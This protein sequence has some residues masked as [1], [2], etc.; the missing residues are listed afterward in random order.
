MLG[1][2]LGE[3]VAATL[4][5]VFSLEDALQVV[6][7]R[8]QL[9]HA[10]PPGAMLA[11]PLGEAEIAPM[12]DDGL[13]VA[14]VNAPSRSVVSGPI[15]SIERLQRRLADEG[16]DGRRLETSHAFHSS[17]MDPVVERFAECVA[18]VTLRPPAHTWMSNVTGEPI[19]AADATDPSYWARHLRQP[20]RFAPAAQRLL[21]DPATVFLEVGPGRTLTTLL[22][23]QPE[24]T[25]GRVLATSLRHPDDASEDMA[26]MAEAVGRLWSGGVSIDWLAV[27][28]HERLRRVPLPTYPFKRQRYWIEPAANR[29]EA[30][31]A[32]RTPAKRADVASWFYL[33]SWKRA[34]PPQSSAAPFAGHTI[35][36][37][38]RHGLGARL[39]DDLRRAG[40]VVQ[41]SG[42]EDAPLLM[43][44]LPEEAAVRVIDCTTLGG[45]R[46]ARS[47]PHQRALYGEPEA[48]ADLLHV[49][50]LCRTIARSTREVELVVVTDGLEAVTGTERIAPDKATIA[51]PLMVLS[52]ER[53]GVTSRTID[54]SGWPEEHPASLLA[55]LVLEIAGGRD[56]VVAWRHG[57]RWV[58]AYEP[59]TIERGPAP[60]RDRGAYLITGGLGG[61]GLILADHMATTYGARLA[62]VGRSASAVRSALVAPPDA[63][64]DAESAFREHRALVDRSVAEADRTLRIRGLDAYPGLE[65]AIEGLCASYVMVLAGQAGIDVRPGSGFDA[66]DLARRLGAIAPF[67][68]MCGYFE[69]VLLEDGLVA[70]D[71]GRLTFTSAASDAAPSGEL[72]RRALAAYPQFAGMF[73]LLDD[74]AA[75][76]PAALSGVIPAIGVLYPD[77]EPA[78]LERAAARTVAHSTR[79]VYL[80]AI[81]D[82]IVG[83][84][85]RHP[86]RRVRV[87]E[88]G[89]GDG[90]L[91]GVVAPA[92]Q[93]LPV[94][95]HA[96]DL[97]RSFVSRAERA[98]AAAGLGHVMRFGV[99]DI[100]RDPAG[101][102]YEP[103]SFDVVLALDVLHATPDLQETLG[104]VRTLLAPGGLAAIVET[105]RAPRWVDFIWGLAEGWWA[106]RD[107]WRLRHSPLIGVEEWTRVCRACG[108]TQVASWPSAPGDRAGDYGL[109]LAQ[110]PAAGVEPHAVRTVRRLRERGSEVLVL[111]ADVADEA[112]MR[113]AIDETVKQ[114]GRLDGVIHAAGVTGRDVI[115]NPIES[116]GRAELDAVLHAKVTGT[117]VLD[118]LLAER[119]VDF[120]LLVSSNASVLGGLGLSAYAAASR[121]LD[122]FAAARHQEGDRRWISSNW[123]G[124]PTEAAAGF[125]S[126]FQT[127]I[128]RY[129]MSL[130]ECRVAFERVLGAGVPQ[131]VVS[132]G[133][134]APRLHRW[135][136]SGSGADALRPVEGQAS[137]SFDA[138]ARPDASAPFEAPQTH[139]ERALAAIW[140]D[141]LGVHPIGSGDVFADLGGDSLLG[142]QL[143]SRVER[144]FG[145]RMPFRMLF[146]AP[147]VRQQ[148]QCIDRIV[149]ERQAGRKG[150]PYD[151]AEADLVTSGFTPRPV[152]PDDR[153]PVLPAQDSYPLSHAQR[154]VWVLSQ[155][156]GS[157]AYNIPLHQ[158]LDG[159]LDVPALEQAITCLVER[160]ETLRT[161]FVVA[162][163]EPR[164]RVDP[165]APVPLP[166]VDL[167]AGADADQR[168]RGLADASASDP[169]DLAAD[170]FRISLLRLARDR[171]IL[172]FTIHHIACDGVSIGILVRDLAELYRA[173]AGGAAPRLPALAVQ[174]RDYAG[175]QHRMLESGALDAER[176][177]WLRQLGADPAAG[178]AP[179]PA[180]GLRGDFPR[181]AVQTFRGRERAWHL[182]PEAARRVAGLA[183]ARHVSL[184]MLLSACVKVLL[185]R[186]TGQGD[187]VIGTPVAGR[188]HQDLEGQIGFYLNMLALRDT[189]RASMRFVDV[190]EAVR[191]TATAAYDRQAYPF[192]RLVDELE[193]ERDLSRSPIFDVIVMLQNQQESELALEGLQARPYFDHNGTSKA[194]LTFNFKESARGLA[195][196]I[197]Y[198]TDLFSDGRVGQIGGHLLRVLDAVTRDPL[199]AIGSIELLSP[200]ERASLEAFNDTECRY[201]RDLTVVDLV[202]R[203]AAESSERTAC[204]CGAGSLSYRDLVARSES[205]AAMLEQQGVRPGDTV[206]LYVERSIDLLPALLGI[207][208]TG[209]AYVPLDPAFPA[210]R[211]RFMVDDAKA[212]LVLAGTPLPAE[213]EGV[214]S[215]CLQDP[216]PA[217]AGHNVRA[218]SRGLAYVIY[219]S[220]STGRPKGVAIEHRSLVNF[221]DSMQLEPGLGSDDTLLAVTTLSFD[222]AALELF[223]PLVCGA[224]V[225]I[226]SREEATD[227]VRLQAL[228]RE[229]GATV[230]QATPATW[231]ML[232]ES[233]WQGD[234]RLTAL[235]GGEALPH[236]LA[237]R[238]SRLCRRVWNMYGPTET[239]IWSSTFD[240]TS[241]LEEDETPAGETMAIGWPIANTSMHVL[242]AGGQPAPAGVPGELYIGGEGLA[243][244]YVNLPDVTAERFVP[245]PF[246]ARHGARM[247]RTGDLAVRRADS[248]IEFLGRLDDQVKLRGFRIE[249]GEIE[250]ALLGHPDVA[251]AAVVLEQTA[252]G[253]RLLA[254]VVPRTPVPPAEEAGVIDGLRQHLRQRLP[255]YMVPGAFVA[256]DDLPRTP[257]GKVDRT[258]L[259]ARPAASDACR[260]VMLP[261]TPMEQRV[262]AAWA[263]V[264]DVATVDVHAD[265]FQL[266]GHSLTAARLA[267]RMAGA[268]GVQLTLMD[269][270]QHPT[271]AALA[272]LVDERAADGCDGAPAR[273]DRAIPIA[274]MTADEIDL[275]GE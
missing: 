167:T 101:Q 173:A 230:M 23:L 235:C 232:L 163:G 119:R 269:I 80:Q 131:V 82:A 90:I 159:P 65:A 125:D 97:G 149:E 41:E 171:H 238:L 37:L 206:G 156:G 53:P 152:A 83:L 98:A 27:H 189:L 5:G 52:Q 158:A 70:R 175:W 254:A 245:D 239:T 75:T 180:L 198:S 212:A 71:G 246:A 248:T 141:L 237:S 160:H 191:A 61:V 209:A 205:I 178:R 247:Y 137:A 226:A 121:F 231:Q 105:V 267:Y 44:S 204:C 39:A 225:V 50:H 132:S 129:A 120:I 146:E 24:G 164:Q 184:F 213:F 62:L 1:H 7:A 35:V 193:P 48:P 14:S 177:Y 258:A 241:A 85:A 68:R 219:T 55:A 56:R 260:P 16:L 274:P 69:Q 273:R 200:Q 168:A 203:T 51:G 116:T 172:L 108:Y 134:L 218:T 271:V 233:G 64:P 115:V 66:G 123:D 251:R 103:G 253:P 133:D 33:P 249:I 18:R 229:S 154:R 20:V 127:S 155:L 255:E 76:Y 227:G 139:T 165:P 3:Y 111:E 192:D 67:D 257:N 74:C 45:D 162:D 234:R 126:R 10:L 240:V 222:I 36:I 179:A 143:I 174:Y 236:A 224:H 91:A 196:G 17:A 228:L 130:E 29:D 8:A 243:R 32:L 107:A 266:G 26:V 78:R 208:S 46:F 186:Y 15:A 182:P 73:E 202:R 81:R 157:T 264:L 147:T 28:H 42:V 49:F 60:I 12:L 87:L 104:H 211:L 256:L 136:A 272:R 153:I 2:S 102:G 109:I 181:P 201:D 244:G 95:Y 263:D 40:Q 223:L 185:F 6:A 110:A 63:D 124:W 176:A 161:R 199:L 150:A 215:V 93:D 38:D 22:R 242:D 148:A 144:Q 188:T 220:G 194:D 9:M 94:E 187:L 259:R 21:R 270:F 114:F 88:V 31:A 140:E 30:P 25:A 170:T 216:G 59:A 89:V 252:G 169:F 106:F 207:L 96:T 43:S 145:C 195:V 151:S 57:Y 47:V 135:L 190:L 19:A 34:V 112:A 128:D 250:N 166:V 142:T 210:E 117:K 183:R 79:D 77:G 92:L 268:T 113:A 122:A 58:R 265:F 221:L 72:L 11:V 84:C 262:A 13:S 138:H 261:S 4:A 118:G 197:E 275:L 54:I 86:D 217:E 214:R 99:L 100:S